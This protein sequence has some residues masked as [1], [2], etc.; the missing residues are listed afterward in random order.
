M[1]QPNPAAVLEDETTIT[2]TTTALPQW[3]RPSYHDLR[4]GKPDLGAAAENWP[5]TMKSGGTSATSRSPS[6]ATPSE[7]SNC[8]APS[9]TSSWATSARPATDC[10]FPND[11][12]RDADRCGNRREDDIPRMPGRPVTPVSRFARSV[13]GHSTRSPGRPSSLKNAISVRDGVENKPT[14]GF[15]NVESDISESE[16]E[17]VGDDTDTDDDDNE[18]SGQNGNLESAVITAVDGDLSMAAF[19]IPLI[20]R[21]FNVALKSKVLS[22]QCTTTTHGGAGGSPG[23]KTSGSRGE[24]SQ[25]QGSGN[26]RKRR[27]RSGSDGGGREG[28]GGWDG[29]DG[30]DDEDNNG[31]LGPGLDT[32]G[33]E[34]TPLLACPF[35]KRDPVKYGIQHGSS[36]SMKKYKYRPCM[37]PGFKSIQRLKEHLKR[38][39]SPV[40]CERCYEIFP[41]TIKERPAC[42]SRLAEHRKMDISCERGDPANKEGI[43]EAQ[44]AALE[45]QNRKKN[46]EIHRLEKW[47]EIWDVLFPGVKRPENPWHDIVVPFQ[48]SSYGEDFA[49]LFVSM[50]EHKVRQGDIDEKA[51]KTVQE[52]MSSV[53]QKAFKTYV[54]I[55][56]NPL[57]ETTSSSESKNRQSL[58]GGSSTHLSAPATTASNQLT[59]TTAATSIVTAPTRRSRSYTVN[60]GYGMAMSPMT[61]QPGQPQ[62]FMPPPMP[63]VPAGT[64]M[65]AFAGM[66]GDDPNG[67][68]YGNM[69][70]PQNSWGPNN[71]QFPPP[72]IFQNFNMSGTDYYQVGEPQ[73]FGSGPTEDV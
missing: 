6:P 36:G 67:Y 29:D 71:V 5:L 64:S 40:Q 52:V 57:T 62:Q 38:A 58:V 25:G 63:Q 27:R 7:S 68:Y 28:V 73:N 18:W 59:A 43:D 10:G 17:T 50:M 31:D 30:D 47:N 20:H 14:E 32:A 26:S 48:S 35:N 8:Y 19:L 9:S 33:A 72:H 46:Q 39:H 37:G 13:R 61:Q 54:N 34:S 15:E 69:F 41:G 1:T 24:S 2:T 23:G 16:S 21:N 66:G 45:R 70:S 44:W 11:E 49:K 53:A 42:L 65:P 55:H 56:G 3:S 60:P 22:W 51:F 12:D 4:F